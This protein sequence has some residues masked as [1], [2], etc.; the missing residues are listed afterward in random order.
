MD[1]IN[2]FKVAMIDSRGKTNQSDI[3]E[4]VTLS[5]AEC[6]NLLADILLEMALEESSNEPS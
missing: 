2:S 6:I 4:I 5:E 3:A 1:I